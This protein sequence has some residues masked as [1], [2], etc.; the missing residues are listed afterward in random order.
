MKKQ[1]E[2][3]YQML[4]QS[5][6][7]SLQTAYNDLKKANIKVIE[8]RFIGADGRQVVYAGE[9]KRVKRMNDL[10]KEVERLSIEV[11]HYRNVLE[12]KGEKHG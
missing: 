4:F 8:N 1:N 2:P 6:V 12:S 3:N 10:A 9:E 5:A 7:S 11:E